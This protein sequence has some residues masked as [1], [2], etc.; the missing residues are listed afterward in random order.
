RARGRERRLRRATRA[1]RGG[2]GRAGRRAGGEGG[3]GGA[4]AG[5]PAAPMGREPR[6]RRGDD[7]AHVPARAPR[8]GGR[9]AV[10]PDRGH[11]GAVLG[12][13]ALLPGG[14]GG[15]EAR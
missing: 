8:H 11:G 14:V 2:G 7:G 3:G 6:D 12:G 1:G 5:R 10:P 15:G 9:G 13:R 4:G